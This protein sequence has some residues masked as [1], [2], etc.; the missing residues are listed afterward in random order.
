MVI[1]VTAHGFYADDIISANRA[2]FY[3]VHGNNVHSIKGRAAAQI[4]VNKYLADNGIDW[5]SYYI[6]RTKTVSDNGRDRRA[7]ITVEVDLAA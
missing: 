3:G 5:N 4:V 1:T 2:S 7:D 6:T